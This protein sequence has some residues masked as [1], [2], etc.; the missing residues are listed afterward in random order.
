ME[1]IEHLMGR[2]I[3]VYQNPD[4]SWTIQKIPTPADDR[5]YLNAA[6]CA[7][8]LTGFTSREEAIE[9]AL[10]FL[11]TANQVEY[12]MEAKYNNGLGPRFKSLGTITAASEAIAHQ[13]AREEAVKAF[14]DPKIKWEVRVLPKALFQQKTCSN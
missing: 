3:L 13:A 6:E 10:E 5:I 7:A 12:V 8:Q 14:T 2:G 9:A 4:Q 1:V 11:Q